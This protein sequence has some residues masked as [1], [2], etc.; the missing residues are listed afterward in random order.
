MSGRGISAAARRRLPCHDEE[1]G[2]IPFLLL[3]M[4][5][6][7]ALGG[8][9]M[10]SILDQTRTTRFD[11]TRARSLDSA[12]A[13]LEFV[14]GQIRTAISDTDSTGGDAA[15][16]P[17]GPWS[18]IPADTS[19]TS[20][21]AASIR[22]YT[23]N[24][25][26][27]TDAQRDSKKML[28]SNS[29]GPYDRAAA[30]RTPHFAVIEA[31][32]VDRSVTGT[33][34]SRGR[35]IETT[36]VFQTND[37]NVSGGQLRIFPSG[38]GNWCMD[39]G[40]NPAAGT[41]VTLQPCST[42]NPAASQQVFSYRSDLSIELVSSSAPPAVGLC[43][44]TANPT[45]HMAGQPIL[46]RNCAV[47]DEAPIQPGATFV[48]PAGFTPQSFKLANPTRN[49]AV[50]PYNQQWSVDDNAHL[51]GAR[52]DQSDTDGFCIDV[53]SQTAGT[54]LLLQTCAGSVTDT[55][56]TW[57]PA[58]TT[59]AG[60]AGAGNQQL[61][62]FYQF[63]TCLDVTGQ[64][65]NAAFLIAYTCK[66][67]PNPSRVAWNQRFAPSPTLN[68]AP[69]GVLLTTTQGGTTYC[70]RSPLSLGGYPVLSSPCPTGPTGAYRW[71]VSQRYS[72]NASGSPELPYSDR[73]TIKD[74]SSIPLC[75]GLGPG[76]D[77]LNGAYYK[78]TVDACDGT[79]A[80]KWNADPSK[81][82]ASLTNTRERETTVGN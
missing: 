4:I 12:Q 11:Q 33:G 6:T 46:L 39:A 71:T 45:A 3:V 2:S 21:F 40:T 15:K 50:S 57:I 72:T 32:G 59:G 77:L 62:N 49:C 56:Q 48:C 55:R 74:S 8:V 43:L 41:A 58:P 47:A 42:S 66:Q 79:T 81:L 53:A 16:L 52:A 38:S 27:Y 67:N 29:A 37:V 54:A 61:V 70:L 10:S 5:L 23:A 78:I 18:D 1:R 9:L 25:L 80:Q 69:T 76:N 20:T 82:K 24:P 36:Y 30:T 22:Y 63:A 19:S 60:M 35:T 64:D 75:L 73:Y 31:T 65:V 51:R 7:V 34:V 68:Q 17:C 28:C 44:D 14:L 26:L 13:G